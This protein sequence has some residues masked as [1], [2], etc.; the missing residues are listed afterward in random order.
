MNNTLFVLITKKSI[1][2]GMLNNN[3]KIHI[4]FTKFYILLLNVTPE[5]KLLLFV[6]DFFI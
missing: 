5:T 6:D 1:Y 4:T 3:Q 2:K